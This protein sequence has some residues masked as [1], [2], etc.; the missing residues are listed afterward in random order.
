MPHLRLTAVLF[1]AILTTTY[2]A[3]QHSFNVS[4]ADSIFSSWKGNNNPGGAVA[5]VKNG[6]AIYE[7]VNG[8]ANIATGRPIGF[9]TQ[10]WIASVTKQFT[11]AAIYL[12][13]AENKIALKDPVTKY[14]PGLPGIYTEVT[15]DH[16]LHHTSGLRDGFV[17][18][19][20][21]KN[22]ESEYTNDNVLKYLI[23]QKELNFKP[24]DQ[25]EYNN[26]GY[27]L[28]ALVI[29]KVSNESYPEFMQFHIFVPAGMNNTF[30]T[31]K[32]E[33]NEV[34]A[35]GYKN[36]NGSFEAAHF[37]GNAYGSTGIITTLRDLE[38]WA[39]QF[40]SL[41]TTNRFNSIFRKMKETG[42]LNNGQA[43]AYGG[44]V[45]KLKYNG[46]DVYEHFGADEGFKAKIVY[47][48]S[49]NVS[50]IG[51]S[52]N[53]SDYQLSEKLYALGDLA[54][55]NKHITGILPHKDTVSR[56]GVKNLKLSRK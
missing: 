5:V 13:A 14:L 39:A 27:V 40:Q 31:G 10:F 6:K 44:G 30:V 9:D 55:G 16:L 46:M 8:M 19:A 38:L 43:I 33:N 17:F 21:A 52:N 34:L 15:I 7:S 29:E 25:Y 32:Y 26:S 3:G 42:H 47:F 23:K 22:A 11:A 35:E 45:E 20:L 2:V 12:L 36:N 56:E 51:L 4:A 53:S 54:M 49:S 28:L 18:T 41:S 37:S 50:V 1:S 24:G 48:P